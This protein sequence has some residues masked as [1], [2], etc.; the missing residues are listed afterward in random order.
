[1]K[2]A[3]GK[4][5]PKLSAADGDHSHDFAYGEVMSTLNSLNSTESN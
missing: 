3:A 2:F 1:M 4:F 5:H